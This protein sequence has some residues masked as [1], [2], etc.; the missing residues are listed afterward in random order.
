MKPIDYLLFLMPSAFLVLVAC[1]GIGASIEKRAAKPR[2][3][4][5]QE[6]LITACDEISM[7]LSLLF[8]FT[9]AMVLSRF[10]PRE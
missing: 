3:D 9:L 5:F 6:Q 10:D 7:F 8:G 4:G 2:T 1:V